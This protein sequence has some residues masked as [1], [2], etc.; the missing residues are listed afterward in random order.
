MNNKR[1]LCMNLANVLRINETKM[2]QFLKIRDICEH[3]T[4]NDGITVEIEL[5]DNNIVRYLIEGTRCKFTCTFNAIDKTVIRKPRNAKP[6]FTTWVK[7]NCSYV[8]EM[9]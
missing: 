6:F 3:L 2:N 1:Q 9:I 4:S 5:Y 7:M 8:L